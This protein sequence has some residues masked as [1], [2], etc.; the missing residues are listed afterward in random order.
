MKGPLPG[1]VAALLLVPLLAS[2]G[3]STPV[4]GGQAKSHL[5]VAS[6]DLVAFKKQTDIPNC[7]RLPSTTTVKAGMPD[8]TLPCLGGGRSVDL[9]GL[10]GPMIVNFWASWCSECRKEMPALAAYAKSQSA[11]KVFGVDFLDT[12]PGAALE[13]A[14]SSA[15]GYPLVADPGGALDRAAPLPHIPGLPVTAFIDANGAIV[16]LEAGSMPTRA[17]VAAAA[18]KYLGA[19]G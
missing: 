14:R 17:D 13:L 4:Q 3:P 12:Q 18:K 9:A 15:V 16:R 1:V 19:G 7:P 2:C 8:V 6:P 10:R 5:N 11:V